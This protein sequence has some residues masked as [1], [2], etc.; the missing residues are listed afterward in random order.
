[1]MH[2]PLPEARFFFSTTPLPCPYL[3]GRVERRVVTELMGSDAADLHDALSLAG[4]RRSHAIA[5]AP[6]CPHCDACI[7]VRINVAGFKPSRGQRRIFKANA[8]IKS[9]EANAVAT[10]EQFALFSA[11]QS[12]RHRDGDMAD[13]TFND[14]QILVESTPVKTSL[15]EYRD[16]DQHLVAACLIDRLGDGLSAVYSFFDPD[17]G[18]RSL[19]TYMI[20]WMV[21]RARDLG[22]PYVYLGFWIENCSKMSYKAAFHPVERFTADGWQPFNP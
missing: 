1:M 16:S 4:F 15:A 12:S 11:Y 7:P 2:E 10:Q 5:Y 8:D 21:D 18:R 22:L 14:Y 6:A 13:M 3:P 20:L 19:G 9:V 17:L